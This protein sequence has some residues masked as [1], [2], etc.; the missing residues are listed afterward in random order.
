MKKV[1]ESAEMRNMRKKTGTK[2]QLREMYAAQRVVF[3]GNT[4]TRSMRS[5]KDYSRKWAIDDYC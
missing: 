4:G 3:S 5:G 2:K 1:R